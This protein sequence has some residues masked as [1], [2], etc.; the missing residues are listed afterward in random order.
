MKIKK[1]SC[2]GVLSK[3]ECLKALKQFA[4]NKSPG[5]D[6]L[7]AEFYLH[8]WDSISELVVDSFNFAFQKGELSISQR[9]GL[10]RL[11][12]KKS[13]SLYFLKAW[14]PLSLLNI[15]Y[16]IATKALAARLKAVAPHLIKCSQTGYLQGRSIGQNIRLI[17]DLLHYT[18]EQNIGGIATFLDFEK[19]FDSLEWEFLFKTL[20][21]FNFGIGFITWIKVLYSNIS[22][23]TLNNGY[24][25]DTFAIKRGVRQ[26]CPISGLLFTLAVEILAHAIRENSD[27]KGIQVFDKEIKLSQYADDTTVFCHD[28]TSLKKALDIIQTFE[29]CS[30]LKVNTSKSEAIW[31]GKDAERR[32]KPFN[33]LWPDKPVT[34]L[35]ITFSY[36]KKSC[37]QENF[38]N[39]ITKIQKLF[40]IWSQRE[41]SLLG[42]ITIMKALGLAKM[43]FSSSFLHTPP[44]VIDTVNRKLDFFLWS[45]KPHKIKKKTI[46]GPK[47]KGGL[48][49]PDY[50][51]VC[52]SLLAT[53]VQKMIAG[54]DD[55]WM[56][57]PLFYLR[58]VGGNF[59]FK[60][61][62]D[63]DLLNIPALP[64]FYRDVLGAWKEAQESDSVINE[65]SNV[66]AQ[67]I[68]NNRSVLIG[69]KSVFWLKWY[70]A[71]IITIGDLLNDQQ[72]FLT[73]SEFCCKTGLKPAFTKLWGLIAAI[74]ARWKE[75]LREPGSAFIP[76][77]VEKQKQILTA[78]SARVL[79]VAQ[80]F[81]EPLANSRL[82][83]EGVDRE[84]LEEVH[85]LPF[86]LSCDTKL[87][88]FQYKLTHNIIAH[89]AWLFKMKLSE[90]PLCS[91]CQEIE[92]VEH[93]FI[94]CPTSLRFWNQVFTRWNTINCD[95]IHIKEKRIL[96]GYL[97]NQ[98]NWPSFNYLLLVGKYFIFVC[99]KE[100][101]LP[102]LDS[103]L[104]FMKWRLIIEN[105]CSKLMSTQRELLSAFVG[106]QN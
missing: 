55:D 63:V 59:I 32:D 16:K 56:L 45:G 11:I 39:K 12:P 72:T 91:Y 23:C 79:L 35:G 15:D 74:P 7:T 17:S 106:N 5:S 70:E 103:F 98:N 34:A 66:M 87:C 76:K 49:H 51:I 38:T 101:N 41:L 61:D 50:A 2:E 93:L 37:E 10:I 75:L 43:I 85:L 36:D 105:R 46:I 21:T 64:V 26:G 54:A 65:K 1:T 14:R 92:T 83:R 6:G 44:E 3:D 53:W 33:L 82:E 24:A 42:K 84:I 47:R 78:K 27:I 30:G 13:K 31:L 57:I 95:K 81:E 100:Q 22:S 97:P 9:L 99:R 28:E 4:R 94:S 67:I 18:K 96:Y 104:S 68:W 19:A 71:G 73:Y 90:T 88:I 29:S 48:D 77:P 8:M 58:S 25:S 86:N 62:Y 40:N 80:A 102:N 52:K 69:G 89:K 60:C 20:E